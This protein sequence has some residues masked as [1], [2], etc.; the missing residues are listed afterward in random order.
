[1]K[2]TFANDL[3]NT[4]IKIISSSEKPITWVNVQFVRLDTNE[5]IEN[6]IHFTLDISSEECRTWATITLLHLQKDGTTTHEAAAFDN[7][8]LDFNVT[9]HYAHDAYVGGSSDATYL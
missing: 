7:P 6:V 5:L 1:M 3:K 9:V 8:D 4:N 2:E